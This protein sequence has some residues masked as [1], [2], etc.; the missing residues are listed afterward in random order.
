[1]GLL[2]VRMEI[3]NPQRLEVRASVPLLV[4]TGATYSMIPRAALEKIA[5]NPN[6][7]LPRLSSARSPTR[8][9]WA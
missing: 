3:A 7:A 6:G 5:V 2:E 8:R 9:S 1:M 4:D